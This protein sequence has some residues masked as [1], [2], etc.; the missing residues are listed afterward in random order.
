MLAEH[1]EE[2][3]AEVG[4]VLFEVG[5]E[6]YPFIA[7]REG[8]AK[9]LD[10]SGR[11]IVRHGASGFLGETNLLSGQTVFLTAVVTEPM[12]YVAVDRET[13]RQ[14]A[15][16]GR[17]PLRPAALGLR[18]AA[19]TA[20]EPQGVGI[21]IVG[22]RPRPRD[23]RPGRV[24]APHAPPPLLARPRRGPRRGD[25]DRRD[26]RRG[27]AA[28]AAAGRQ[29]AARA[30]QRRA[31]AGARDRPRAGA[32]RRGRPADRRRRPGRA[33]RRGLR[34]LRG[35]Q[36]AGGRAQRARRPGGDLAADRELPRLP[37]RDQ[38]HRADQPRDRPGAQ[39]QRPHGDALQ[40]ALARAGRRRR[41]H[42]QARGR[43]RSRR[44]GGA[45]LDRRRIP[46][47]AG[48]RPRRIRGPRASSTRPGRPRRSSAGQRGSASSAAATRRRRRPSGWR[49]AAPW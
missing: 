8:E 18:A 16:R 14:P 26:R 23:P 12:R 29:R 40:S 49:K 45:A 33:R 24:R 13:L 22:P 15:L 48:R 10:G 20:A 32:A 30:E 1:G 34:R 4:D 25:A 21:E 43:P 27:A 35:P 7:I 31:L 38:R 44:Q 17:R 9:I 46:Q 5:D 37:L 11:E 19:R 6:T 3:T 41:P 39:V 36:H 28:G 42:R 2:R 47:T